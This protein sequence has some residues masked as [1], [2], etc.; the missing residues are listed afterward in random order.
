M[1]YSLL[2]GF[3]KPR[4]VVS[5]LISGHPIGPVFNLEH[6]IDKLYRNVGNLLLVYAA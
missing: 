4:F 6:E 5:Y 3:M 2:W 1:R